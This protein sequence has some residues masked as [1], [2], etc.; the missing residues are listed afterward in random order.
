MC[1]KPLVSIIIPAYNAEDFLGETLDSILSQEYDNIEVI[2]VDDGSTDQTSKLVKGYQ[3]RVSYYYQ[4]NSGGS[5]IPRNTGIKH[6]SGDFL[7]FFDADDL[8]VSNRIARQVD[9]LTRNPNVGIVFCDYRNF[10]EEGEYLLS[11]FETCSLLWTQL[12]NNNEIILEQACSYLVLENFGICG[13]FMIRR[14]LL[15][16]EEGFEPT[17]RACEDFHFFYRLARHGP[18]GVINEIG[19]MRRLHEKNLTGDIIKMLSEGIRSRTLLRDS[20]QDPVNRIHIDNYIID[21]KGS[22]A[23]FYTNQGLFLES[24]RLDWDALSGHCSW[25]HGRARYKNILR[26]ILMAIGVFKPKK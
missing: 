14:S 11:H 25:T 17:L 22:L 24:L 21:C 10:S 8:M 13:S 12:K 7:C 20:E 15:Q 1:V 9:F 19:M 5:A 2:V 6:S 18:V 16:L 3:P 26:T 23:R 4:N